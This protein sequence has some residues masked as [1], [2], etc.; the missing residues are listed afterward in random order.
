MHTI[1]VATV[2]RRIGNRKEPDLQLFAEFRPK[3]KGTNLY[4]LVGR[5]LSR[6]LDRATGL[7]AEAVPYAARHTFATW[8]SNDMT[9]ITDHALRRYIGHKPEG[10]TDKF[11]RSVKPEALLAVAG[12][13][14]YPQAVEACMRKQ[15]AL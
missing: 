7:P 8:V 6:H 11:Y 2:K 3:G 10:M 13:V 9:G 15:L 1:A 5:A 4:E 12:K 14:Q